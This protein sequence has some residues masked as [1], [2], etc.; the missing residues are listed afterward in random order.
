MNK[1]IKIYVIEDDKAVRE[2]LLKL[3]NNNSYD[4]SYSKDF[5]NINQDIKLYQPDIILLDINLPYN[6]GFQICEEL[7]KITNSSIIFVTCRNTENDELKSILS[8]GDDYIVKPYNTMILLEKIKRLIN[9]NNP[10]LYKEIIVKNVILDLH[11]SSIKY[12]NKEIELSRNEFKILYFLFLNNGRLVTKDEL[13][14]YLWNNKFYIDENILNVN[15][16]RIR[17]KLEEINIKDFIKTIHGQGY[18]I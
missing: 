2:E 13:I 12:N 15:I 16:T 5:K 17:K 9:K 6:N 8:G 4:T 11:L 18:E 3:V 1:K 7:K 10:Q 14:E